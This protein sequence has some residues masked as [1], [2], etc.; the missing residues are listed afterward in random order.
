METFRQIIVLGKTNVFEALRK[1][2]QESGKIEISDLW[3]ALAAFGGFAILLFVLANLFSA[4]EK[5]RA[6]NSP[7]RL[8]WELCRTHKIKLSQRWLLW[9]IARAH[10]LQDPGILFVEPELFDADLLGA[11]FK[12]KAAAIASLH[13]QLFAGLAENRN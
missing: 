13:R 8:F 1:H 11:A 5:K 4:R 10:E 6:A 3:L 7:L 12:G 9:R 2:S